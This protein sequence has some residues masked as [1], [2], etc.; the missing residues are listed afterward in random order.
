MSNKLSELRDLKAMYEI[1]LESANVD[2]SLKDHYQT[3]LDMINEKIEKNQIFRRYF[4][5]RLDKTEICPSCD[6]EMLSHEKDQ[7]LQCMRNF[8]E[9]QWFLGTKNSHSKFG[10]F[11][12]NA[13]LLESFQFFTFAFVIF[14]ST[15]IA[16][17]SSCI[18]FIS[19]SKSCLVKRLHNLSRNVNGS[20]LV[21]WLLRHES[22]VYYVFKSTKSS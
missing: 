12:P 19:H 5:G 1:R 10:C 6:K 13:L 18:T 15:F 8:V 14:Q 9:K 3:M 20:N 17:M 2:K 11:Q 4:N 22:H 16:I 21:Q 7:A